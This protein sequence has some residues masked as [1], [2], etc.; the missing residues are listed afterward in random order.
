ML[1]KMDIPS[2]LKTGVL[3]ISKRAGAQMVLIGKNQQRIVAA[4]GT[5]GASIGICGIDG[6]L[7]NAKN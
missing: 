7:M 4:L 3:Q 1:L 2:R 6:P 5:K